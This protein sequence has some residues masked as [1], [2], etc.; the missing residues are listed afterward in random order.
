MLQIF[1]ID[2]FNFSCLVYF[3]QSFCAYKKKKDFWDRLSLCSLDWPWT[4]DPPACPCWV[5]EFWARMATP[6]SLG[7]LI[8]LNQLSFYL[9]SFCQHDTWKISLSLKKREIFFYF[10]L[11]DVL[12]RPFI[13]SRVYFTV[14]DCTVCVWV[15]HVSSKPLAWFINQEFLSTLFCWWLLLIH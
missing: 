13:L 14:H 1:F 12:V 2:Y 11:F 9:Y 7:L 10:L 6:S 3:P 15:N 4:S 8:V 5:M